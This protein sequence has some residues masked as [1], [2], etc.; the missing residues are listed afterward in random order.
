MGLALAF[1]RALIYKFD[2][3]FPYILLRVYN[4]TSIISIIILFQCFNGFSQISIKDVSRFG[5]LKEVKN[6]YHFLLSHP[7]DSSKDWISKPGQLKFYD[8]GVNRFFERQA[9][10]KTFEKIKLANL[11]T[12]YIVLH[13]ANQLIEY[14]SDDSIFIER[15]SEYYKKNPP[16]A[17]AD[18][19]KLKNDYFAGFIVHDKFYPAIEM[20]LQESGKLLYLLPIVWFDKTEGEIL[21]NY[22]RKKIKSSRVK[23]ATSVDSLLCSIIKVR[24]KK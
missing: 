18:L 22:S 12:Q 24:K 23:Q 11:Q 17:N 15:K 13:G 7:V 6:L 4:E 9:M 19:D 20:R 2:F 8:T 10:M 14:F 5:N 21:K 1:K 16:D 3:S